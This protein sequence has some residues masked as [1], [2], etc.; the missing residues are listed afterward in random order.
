M[1]SAGV[2]TTVA[3]G[4]DFVWYNPATIYARQELSSQGRYVGYLNDLWESNGLTVALWEERLA[5]LKEQLLT[6]NFK[7]YKNLRQLIS[8][9]V[10]LDDNITLAECINNLVVCN[11]AKP[12]LTVYPTKKTKQR[13]VFDAI[14]GLKNFIH[15]PDSLKAM[16]ESTNLIAK[17][18]LYNQNA[19][20]TVQNTASGEMRERLRTLSVLAREIMPVVYLDAE[21]AQL[22]DIVFSTKHGYS[23]AV[24]PMKENVRKK[25]QMQMTNQSIQ[26]AILSST[27][28]MKVMVASVIERLDRKLAEIT[29]EYMPAKNDN[30]YSIPNLRRILLKLYATEVTEEFFGKAVIPSILKFAGFTINQKNDDA[31]A[32]RDKV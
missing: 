19:Y 9:V 5:D 24:I 23:F 10:H 15:T 32:I 14:T 18:Q 26:V 29:M 20:E 30:I 13:E 3:E 16:R 12:T 25:Q 28:H 1:V 17:L 22:L 31:D 4:K 7:F 8:I 27:K 2:E 21:T 11:Y 6:D